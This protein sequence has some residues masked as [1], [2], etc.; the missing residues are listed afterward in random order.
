[1]KKIPEIWHL[2]PEKSTYFLKKQ[3]DEFNRIKPFKGLKILSNLHLTK[4]TICKLAPLMVSG[5]KLKVTATKDLVKN[6]EVITYFSQEGIYVDPKKIQED[7]YDIVLDCGASLIEKIHPTLGFIELTK[8]VD[9][10]KYKKNTFNYINIDKTK[11]KEIENFYG[12]GDGFLRALLEQ[13]LEINNKGFLIFGYGKVGQGI[14]QALYPFT[15]SI[16]IVEIDEDKI[17]DARK[18]GIEAFNIRDYQKIKDRLK[19]TFL[20]VTATGEKGFI[21]TYF[22]KEDFKGVYKANMGTYDEWGH[23]FSK[24]EVMGNKNPLNFILSEPTKMKFLDPIFYAHNAAIKF[25][26]HKDGLL[27]KGEIDFPVSE[28]EKILSEWIKIHQL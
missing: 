23:L 1:V 19:N 9:L 7:Q 4:A 13:N 15:R 2:F 24:Q 11:L 3:W 20:S 16:S 28:V 18:K 14:L 5:A 22:K 26:L 12:T 25:L 17:K 27:T 6:K 21:S 8:S 10:E